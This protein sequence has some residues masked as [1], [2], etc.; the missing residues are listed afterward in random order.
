MC[1]NTDIATLTQVRPFKGHWTCPLMER[2]FLSWAC[3][4]A[5]HYSWAP[6]MKNG[7]FHCTH[8][9]EIY[10]AHANRV[11]ITIYTLLMRRAANTITVWQF[12]VCSV[13]D[14]NRRGASVCTA[15]CSPAASSPPLGGL[16]HSRLCFYITTNNA[17]TNIVEQLL[18]QY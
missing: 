10:P 18:V 13:C 12:S 2:N 4:N 8:W 11:S 5:S 14:N 1:D 15:G 6:I 16:Q 3:R 17:A 7:T 9:D